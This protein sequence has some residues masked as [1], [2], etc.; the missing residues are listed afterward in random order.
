MIW[1]FYDINSSIKWPL[2]IQESEIKKIKKY[3]LGL[4]ITTNN[5]MS[6]INEML[7]K[8]ESIGFYA[9]GSEYGFSLRD[10]SNI[11]YFDSDD[12]KFGLKLFRGLPKVESPMN[13]IKE[14]VDGIITDYP[15]S[16]LMVMR[17]MNI[18]IKKN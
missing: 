13:L 7:S 4:E 9:G 12:Y 15:D 18:H 17:E 6:N 3:K 5:V 2:E 8:G 16:L 14:K 11:R 1:G 10:K